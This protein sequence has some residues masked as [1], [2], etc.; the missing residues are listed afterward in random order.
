MKISMKANSTYI[1]S[2]TAKLLKDCKLESSAYY[3]NGKLI[4]KPL[5]RGKTICA[6]DEIYPAYTWQEILW[7]YPRQFFGDKWRATYPAGGY[8]DEAGY[9]SDIL[10]L[11]QQKEYIEADELFK[12]HCILI[13]E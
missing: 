6:K 3:C 9:P 8:C 10:Y 4:R 2:H 1:S 5:F 7:E 12:T 13:K 11:L